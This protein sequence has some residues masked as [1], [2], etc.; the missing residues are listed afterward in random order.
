VTAVIRRLRSLGLARVVNEW[1]RDISPV[2]PVE[3]TSLLHL[4][5]MRG[6]HNDMHRIGFRRVL[7]LAFTLIHVVLVWFSPE[8][9]SRAVRMVFR[10]SG[11]RAVAY[12][13]GVGVPMEAFGEPPP[14]KPVQKIAV[15]LEL[16]AMFVA[17][18]IGAVLFPRNDAAW[19][20]TSVPFVP[21]VWYAI[22]RWLD[23]LLGYRARLCLPRILRGLLTVLAY[24]VLL[25]SMA[26]LTP[27]YHHRTADTYWMFSG[28]ML[29]SGI[30]LTMMNSSSS[31]TR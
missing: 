28:L 12:Q 31:E 20:Y 10:A 1:N 16:P 4:R 24:L 6:V 18:L 17:M 7:P 30:C 27:L 26:G 2:C 19:L 3:V 22:G 23:G 13:E 5:P 21:L 25:M 29:W 11:Y 8:H 14:L 15:I 9:Q